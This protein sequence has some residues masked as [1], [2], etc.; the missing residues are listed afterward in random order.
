[1]SAIITAS[2]N[3]GGL[4]KNSQIAAADSAVTDTLNV[5]LIGVV[6]D[7]QVSNSTLISDGVSKTEITATLH[8]TA[9]SAL[10]SR[11]IS[12]TTNA[13]NLSAQT[14]LTNSSGQAKVEITSPTAAGQSTITA[15]Y[16]DGI[17]NSTYINF[18]YTLPQV[19]DYTLELSSSESVILADGISTTQITAELKD[20][21]GDPVTGKDIS[22]I[23]TIGTIENTGTTDNLGIAKVTYTGT[24]SS[25]DLT[26]AV[27]A[28]IGLELLPKKANGSAADE[29]IDTLYVALRGIIL[30]VYA[31]SPS[32]LADGASNTD[33]TAVLHTTSDSALGSKTVSFTTN[34]GNL[35]AEE[36]LTD[37]DGNAKVVIT[38]PTTT[39][40]AT[41][42]AS[43]GD[44]IT[45]SAYV[46]FVD[47]PPQVPSYIDVDA[48]LSSLDA[49]EVLSTLSVSAIVSDENRNPVDDG[50]LVSFSLESEVGQIRSP[51]ATSDGTATTTLTYPTEAVGEQITVFAAAGDIADTVT[52]TLP[53][54]AGEVSEIRVFPEAGSGSVLADGLSNMKIIALLLDSDGNPVPNK[55]IN[56]EVVNC[57]GTIEGASVS[58]ALTDEFGYDN[59]DKG[60]ASV[61]LTSIADTVDR[62]PIIRA[63]SGDAEGFSTDTAIVL[64]GVSLRVSPERDTVRIGE[65]VNIEVS[66]KEKTSTIA[67]SGAEI[68]FGTSRGSM[69]KTRYTDDSGEAVNSLSAGNDPGTAEITVRFGNEII[70]KTQV[71]IIQETPYKIIFTN[72]D[73]TDITSLLADGQSTQNIAVKVLDKNDEPFAD[74]TVT[75]STGGIGTVSQ[76]SAVS[77]ASGIAQT[78]YTSMPNYLSPTAKITAQSG[79]VSS[80]TLDIELRGITMTLKAEAY[81]DEKY[82]IVA[83]G[84]TLTPIIAELKETIKGNPLQSGTVYFETD[85]GTITESAAITSGTATVNLKSPDETGSGIITAKYGSTIQ[86]SISVEYY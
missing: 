8:T 66:L 85:Q 3:S 71:E 29:I 73:P 16:V 62:Y 37:A 48:Q 79:S 15:S 13:G 20:D 82:R 72:P 51:V 81:E 21:E 65:E 32:L 2:I 70:S 74:A 7:V 43:Y 75:F 26:S 61:T 46:N 31:S 76:E 10:G 30:N 69:I 5:G 44:G 83:N 25:S 1:M 47:V 12:F 39:G 9:D 49:G 52:I 80:D 67:I 40:Q 36:A 45:N 84:R 28:S 42:T 41:I 77:N 38:S 33:I 23:S 27:I 56:F 19:T 35:S 64:L 53:G 34:A 68:T 17:T 86:Q 60:R 78:T 57:Y 59:P 58:G 24:A 18:V 14:A 6:V 22:F 54:V 50:T 4:L 63:A 55:V 11:T